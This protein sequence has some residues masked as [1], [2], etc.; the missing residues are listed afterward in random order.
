[1]DK[2]SECNMNYVLSENGNECLSV[3]SFDVNNDINC[4]KFLNF[5]K[6]ILCREGAYFLGD[7][8][9]LC[10]SSISCANCN[11]L[12]PFECEICMSGYYMN[13]EK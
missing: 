2:C 4:Q 7:Q 12:K 10:P 9:V 5:P 13:K 8:C 1:M 6:C 11:Q 3:K